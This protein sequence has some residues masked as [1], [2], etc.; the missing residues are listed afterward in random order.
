MLELPEKKY[1]LKDCLPRKSYCTKNF[2]SGLTI[3]PRELALKYRYIQLNP[4]WMRWALVFDLDYGVHPWVAY[5][6]NLP[7]PTFIVQ[8]ESNRRAHLIYAIATPV[9][10]SDAARLAPLRYLEAIERAYRNRLDADPLYAGL[11]AKNPWNLTAWNIWWNEDLVYD[12]NY[13]AESVY[14]ELHPPKPTK[15]EREEI[16][17]LGRNCYIF[18]NVR[19]WAYTAVRGF[20]GPGSEQRWQAAVNARCDEVNATF[21]TPL[22]PIETRCIARSIA[23]WVWLR[24]SP[25]GFSAW[26][27]GN[28][29]K[30]WRSRAKKERGLELLQL[31]LPAS[32]VA[33]DV[34]VT[35]RTVRRWSKEA[36]PELMLPM[37]V[38]QKKPWVPQYVS[39]STWYRRRQLEKDPEAS[40]S[41]LAP[42]EDDGVSR[43]TWY[44]HD[45]EEAERERE[46]P[47]SLTRPW[48]AQGISRATWYRRQNEDEPREAPLN[49]TRPWEAEGISRRTWYRRQEKGS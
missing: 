46:T 27:R 32:T 11:I 10:T 21:P 4:P 42:W 43:A 15:R 3:R 26:Q 19:L 49:S 5:D 29:E 39:R 33:E 22:S 37:S 12:L 48:E 16:A 7:N 30:H 41:I 35:S 13:L 28:S 25:D 47:L 45:G 8:K 9:C 23:K 40:L 2:A 24:F 36:E 34:G 31:G 14:N 38:G 1:E 20:W 6:N 17:G 18:E 44:R